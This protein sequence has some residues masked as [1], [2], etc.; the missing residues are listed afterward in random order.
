MKKAAGCL[1]VLL[2]IVFLTTMCYTKCGSENTERPDKIEA[3]LIS[4]QF[5]EN[6]LKAPGSAEWPSITDDKVKINKI[7]DTI[8]EIYSYVDSQNTF[9]ALIRTQ[10]YCKMK[11][12]KE[13][14][15]WTLIEIDFD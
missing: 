3:F 6:Y 13:D 4:Q 8:W 12:N 2:L 14:E 9:G 10:Y 11:Y 7:D 15:N 1:I 5:V